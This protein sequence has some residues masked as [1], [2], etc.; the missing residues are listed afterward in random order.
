[1]S[2]ETHDIIIRVTVGGHKDEFNPADMVDHIR[3]QV[4]AELRDYETRVQ[5]KRPAVYLGMEGGQFEIVVME[6]W[7]S[8]PVEELLPTEEPPC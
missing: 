4:F 5:E 6:A 8:G 3:D 7:H 2:R 1:M